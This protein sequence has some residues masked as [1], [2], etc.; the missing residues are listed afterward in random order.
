MARATQI[1]YWC[2]SLKARAWG[3]FCS[4]LM[5]QPPF[6]KTL[7]LY[8]NFHKTDDIIFLLFFFI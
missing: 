8:F 6:S 4:Y 7:F 5:N 3:K 2:F 1:V